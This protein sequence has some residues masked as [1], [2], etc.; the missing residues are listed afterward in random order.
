MHFDDRLAG[1][2]GQQDVA[3]ATLRRRPGGTLE[4]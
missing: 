1:V 4:K 3:L 2:V